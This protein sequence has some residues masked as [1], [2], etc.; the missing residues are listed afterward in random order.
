MES[1][2]KYII[3]DGIRLNIIKNEKE[4]NKVF[5]FF[6][7]EA[8]RETAAAKAVLAACMKLGNGIYENITETEYAAAENGIA[9]WDIYTA[10]KG[11]EHILCFSFY[12]N[13]EKNL[14]NVFKFIRDIIFYPCAD[15]Y[16]F[17][18]TD[19]G[20]FYVKNVIRSLCDDFKVYGKMRF[21]EEMGKKRN[22]G[23]RENGFYDET[24]S[25]NGN[26]LKNTYL[27]IIHSSP[28]EIYYCGEGQEELIR[29][30]AQKT[31]AFTRYAVSEAEGNSIFTAGRKKA[32]KEKRNIS[33]SI[34]YF[35]FVPKKDLGKENILPLMVLSEIIGGQNG[36]L[37]SE[38]REKTG[39]CYYIKSGLF[40]FKHV[41]W[42]EMAIKKEDL[43][44]TASMMKQV[45]E[46]IKTAEEIEKRLENAKAAVKSSFEETYENGDMYIDFLL[47]CTIGAINLPKE[48]FIEKTEKIK[49]GDILKCA[50]NLEFDTVFFLEGDK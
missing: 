42:A 19:N 37:Y 36:I 6:R 12:F 41:L 39:L 48:K 1:V 50:E 13:D 11:D 3:G 20:I 16:G 44:K 46:K 9:D 8:Q 21:A 25:L 43:S 40:I 22:F 31:F 27:K 32:L 26:F 10:I 7:T 34:I 28:C 23:I 49:I 30:F 2:K 35:G 47:N 4:T 18:N 17:K 5:V 33:E 29:E 24:D 45:F 38:I 15:K 14:K